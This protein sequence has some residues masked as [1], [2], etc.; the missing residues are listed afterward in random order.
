[1]GFSGVRAA[2]LLV[3]A[4][5]LASACVGSSATGGGSAE[6]HLLVDG[7]T[8]QLRDVSLT[9]ETGDEPWFRLDGEPAEHA[10]ED[11]VPGLSGSLGLYG[12]LPSSVSQPSDLVGQRMKVD[13]SGDGDDANFCFVGMGGLAGAEDAW[14]TIEAVDGDHVTFS[15]TGTF[16]I[17]DE[18]GDGPVKTASA[19]GVAVVRRQT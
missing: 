12:D 5:L 2:V 1:M 11:C 18:N 8:Y 17:Y 13:F 19:S 6:A 14:V 7:T 9:L 3:A 15:M 4:V 10:E 16:K